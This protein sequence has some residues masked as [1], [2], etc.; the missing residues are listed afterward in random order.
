MPFP[1]VH[2]ASLQ[3]GEAALWS[4]VPHSI[5]GPSKCTSNSVATMAINNVAVTTPIVSCFKISPCS[6]WHGVLSKGVTIANIA[7]TLFPH[8]GFMV[9]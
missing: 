6:R 9:S 5:A 1:P 3:Q 4:I 7:I 2:A 8:K